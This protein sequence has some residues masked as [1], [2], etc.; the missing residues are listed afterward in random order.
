M[1]QVEP[2]REAPDFTLH[3]FNDQ[4]FK[5]SDYRGEKNVLLVLNRGFA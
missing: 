5:L 3:D 2:N 1:S 4:E